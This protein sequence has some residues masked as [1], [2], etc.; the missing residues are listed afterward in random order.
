MRPHRGQRRLRSRPLRHC[1]PW[2]LLGRPV[3][4]REIR[5][6]RSPGARELPE[7]ELML[8]VPAIDLRQGRCVRLLQGDFGAETRYEYEPQ[9][10]LVRYRALGASW[11]HVVDLDGAKDGALANRSIIVAL[12]SQRAVR[13]QVGGGVRSAAIVDDL[14]RQGVSRV[15]VGSTAVERP[16][17]VTQWLVR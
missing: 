3:S 8:L 11:L 14:L 17:E 7:V 6:H 4:P 12:A 5:P 1:P 16:E 9:E 10:L 15:V 2:K 13:I